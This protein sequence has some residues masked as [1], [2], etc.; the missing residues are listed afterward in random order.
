MSVHVHDNELTSEIPSKSQWNAFFYKT[1]RGHGIS[2]SPVSPVDIFVF[3]LTYVM[4]DIHAFGCWVWVSCFGDESSLEGPYH[5]WLQDDPLHGK[6]RNRA[7][8]F[9]SEMHKNTISM[10]DAINACA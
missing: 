8:T 9:V 3:L 2:Y 7:S 10:G 1:F 6:V 5:K 4:L